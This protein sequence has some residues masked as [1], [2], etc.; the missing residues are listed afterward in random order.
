MSAAID[1]VQTSTTVELV[2]ELSVLFKSSK[3][4]SIQKY[5]NISK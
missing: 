4:F 2:E 3:R 5:N 1:G